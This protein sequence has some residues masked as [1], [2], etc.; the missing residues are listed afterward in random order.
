MPPRRA[1]GRPP[2]RAGLRALP[3]RRSVFPAAPRGGAPRTP[4]SPGRRWRARYWRRTRRSPA[5]RSAAD[6]C[7]AARARRPCASSPTALRPKASERTRR[8]CALATSLRPAYTP[9]ALFAA[10]AAKGAEQVGD[11]G[12]LGAQGIDAGDAGGEE[13]ALGI[14][15]VELARDRSEERR[16]GKAG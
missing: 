5:C 9:I 7:A 16:V 10:S 11:G 4:A 12:A 8:T 3:A 2:S 13:P 1:A 15:D 6:P 14:D